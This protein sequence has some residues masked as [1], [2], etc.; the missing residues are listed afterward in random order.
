MLFSSSEKNV[1]GDIYVAVRTYTSVSVRKRKAETYGYC[2][3][4]LVKKKLHSFRLFYS[5]NF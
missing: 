3:D 2:N 5:S 1:L 4:F